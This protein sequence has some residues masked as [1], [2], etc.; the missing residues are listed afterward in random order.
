VDPDT[1]ADLDRVGQQDVEV[2][3]AGS[4][5]HGAVGACASSLDEAVG[6]IVGAIDI[7]DETEALREVECS[8]VVVRRHDV[9][10]SGHL[11]HRTEGGLVV[12]GGEVVGVVV[13]ATAGALVV[14]DTGSGSTTTGAVVLED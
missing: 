10:E 5:A 13:L 3:D 8:R 6:G 11:Q 9:V 14:A 4:L 1:V 7:V 12:P 2:A